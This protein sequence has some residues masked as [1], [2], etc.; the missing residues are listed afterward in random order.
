MH[1]PSYSHHTG[2]MKSANLALFRDMIHSFVMVASKY[3][4][5]ALIKSYGEKKTVAHRW[6]IQIKKQKE[7][8]LTA[9]LSLATIAVVKLEGK[10]LMHLHLQSILRSNPNFFS[11]STYSK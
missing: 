10:Q 3:F 4:R 8:D 2:Q 1:A 6:Q 7:K 11:A 5:K 9:K